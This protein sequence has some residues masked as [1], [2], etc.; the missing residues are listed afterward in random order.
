MKKPSVPLD[1]HERL[2]RLE[3]TKQYYVDREGFMT[4]DAHMQII[5]TQPWIFFGDSGHMPCR[6][7]QE[8]YFNYF[9]MIPEHCAYK[10]WK[11]VM[12]PSTVAGLFELHDLMDDLGVHA[13][14]GT[15]LRKNTFGLYL[16]AGYAENEEDGKKLEK[17]FGD[18]ISTLDGEFD[19]FLKKGC[20]EFEDRLPSNLWVATDQQRELEEQIRMDVDHS[21]PENSVQPWWVKESIKIKWVQVAYQAGDPTWSETP[22]ADRIQKSRKAVRY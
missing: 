22:Y 17:L 11:V 21:W 7:R 14:C 13:K 3:A 15:D 19:V 12:R 1:Y 18:H 8:L 6:L 2:A 4:Y 9:G 16:G 10:C 20:T 5:D